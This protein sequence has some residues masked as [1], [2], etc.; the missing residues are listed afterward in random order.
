MGVLI[1]KRLSDARREGDRIYAV[2]RGVGVASDGRAMG[3]FTPRLEGQ[4]LA[5]RRAY[6]D[7]GV[8]P[9]TVSLI[10]GH[11]TGMPVGDATE[12]A[13][14]H[15]VFGK[16]GVPQVALG[17]VKSMV[18]HLMPAAGMAG[19][20]KTALAVYHRALPPTLHVE[21]PHPELSQGRIYINTRTRPWIAAAGLPE[22]RTIPRRAGVNAFGFGGINTHAVL[23]DLP[24]DSPRELLTPRASELFV[25]TAGSK[26]DLLA[27]LSTWT[28]VLPGLAGAEPPTSATS[29]ERQRRDQPLPSLALRACGADLR[30]LCY[31][32]SL[33]FSAEQPVRLA[34]TA[35]SVANLSAK[36]TRAEQRLAGS[37]EETWVEDD[38][39][40]F[41]SAPY[42]GKVAFLFP[43]LAFPGLAGGYTERLGELCLQFPE[44]RWF[45]DFAETFCEPGDEM[46]YPL[47]HQFFPPPLS[48]AATLA[49][50]ES[51][52]VWS[53][54][55]TSLGQMM[56]ALATWN[57]MQAAGVQPD[58]LAGFSLGEWAALMAAGAIDHQGLHDIF[59]LWKQMGDV[60]EEL[61]GLWGLVDSTDDKVQAV[62]DE[63]GGKVWIIIDS[64]PSQTFI[65]GEPIPVRAV[66]QRFRDEGVFVKEVPLPAI[67]T[68]LALPIVQGMKAMKAGMPVMSPRQRVYCGMNGLP[69]PD[70][71]DQIRDWIIESHSHRLRTGQTLR[72]LYQDGVR[73]FVELGLGG[74]SPRALQTNLGGA[75]H[76]GLL[77]EW[78]NQSCLELFHQT[79]GRLTVLGVPTDLGYLYRNRPC[80]VVDLT[81][82]PVRAAD[83]GLGRKTS[84]QLSLAH[85]R[86]RLSEEAVDGLRKILQPTAPP[87]VPPTP[88]RQPEPAVEAAGRKPSGHLP[89][90]EPVVEAAGRK[91]SGQPEPE[92]LRP[93]ASVA[94]A[95]LAPPVALPAVV[96][97]VS[98]VCKAPQVSAWSGALPCGRGRP[99]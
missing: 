85:P 10:E 89:W 69:Y 29:P 68:P 27:K 12:I 2:I 9:L 63:V 75:P 81:G 53:R 83:A 28:R 32:S 64:P 41:A 98:P 60:P 86:V 72:N 51:E 90:S 96:P 37:A 57:V 84:T 93:T 74:R 78:R 39:T 46:P 34:A 65:A 94:R 61:S 59:G 67:H 38:G 52:L 48:D 3:L 43:G 97:A 40:C 25:L 16:E 95:A 42:P 47:S 23:E 20:I 45:L 13:T 19:L 99:G 88:D 14:L 44:A 8:D 76:V 33:D 18:G 15:Q 77:L 1:L 80:R 87:S 17:S 24:D 58:A 73:I 5:L 30:D 66:L 31:T 6:E 54:K 70:D 4:V 7:S 11:G 92:G 21:K 49:R 79:L 82:A 71:P 56:S 36:L 35:S 55:R 91:P 50:L 22:G 26:A 62:I